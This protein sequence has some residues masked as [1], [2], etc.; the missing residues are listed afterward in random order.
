MDVTTSLNEVSTWAVNQTGFFCSLPKWKI[1]PGG[2][3]K[4]FTEEDGSVEQTGVLRTNCIDCL[5]RTNAAQYSAG[6]DAIAQQL[7]VMGIRSKAKFDL[8]SNIVRVLMDMYVDVGDSIALQYGGSEAHRK[9]TATKN[10]SAI[11]IPGPIGKHKE[12]LTSIRRYY[13]NAFTDRLKQDAMNLFLGYYIPYNHTVPLWDMETD[14][15]LHNFHAQSESMNS[16]KSYQQTFGIDWTSDEVACSPETEKLATVIENAPISSPRTNRQ[17]SNGESQSIQKVRGRCSSQNEMLSC[18]WKTALQSHIKERMWTQVG[19]IELDT[20]VPS[21]FERLYQPEKLSQFDRFFTRNWATPVRRSHSA[22]Q[23]DGPEI[24]PDN[25]GLVRYINED[26]SVIERADERSNRRSHDGETLATYLDKFGYE[27]RSE[28][29]LKDFLD[30][31][32]ANAYT[33]TDFACLG[34]LSSEQGICREYLNYVAPTDPLQK[35]YRA[36]RIEEFKSCLLDT[37]LQSDDV[38]GIEQLAESAHIGKVILSGP[39]SGLTK[40]MS[41]V[42]VATSILEQFNAFQA[43]KSGENDSLESESRSGGRHLAEMEL[44]R[45]GLG[46]EGVVKSVHEGWNAFTTAERHYTE[47]VEGTLDHCTRSNLTTAESLQL[48]SSALEPSSSLSAAEIMFLNGERVA[49]ETQPKPPQRLHVVR[50]GSDS[51]VQKA[52]RLGVPIIPHAEIAKRKIKPLFNFGRVR[53]VP[54]GWE[55]INEDLFAHTTNKF[56][57][58]NGAGIDSWTGNQPI[59]NIAR[60]ETTLLHT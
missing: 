46:S 27:P 25:G 22:Q 1:L 47:I 2:V 55:Q 17:P 32:V 15:Y 38:A 56:M 4:P 50:E 39:Y 51:F 40:D 18:W 33:P 34:S 30:K 53:E 37:T 16:M 24:D 12:L 29:S 14:Y 7:V 21:R 42:H 58:C 5:D 8:S 41:A 45:Q 3:V 19:Q 10:E 59:T 6:L 28:S 36:D 48:Y 11:N 44:E 49:N 9:V 31:T 13:S 20:P 60:H 54:P 43:L 57:V 23:T 35:P 26:S 52:N